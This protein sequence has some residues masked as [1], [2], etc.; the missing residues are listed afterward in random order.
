MAS[1]ILQDLPKEKYP[2]HIA[3]IM[4]G[5]GR[6]AKQRN[7]IR[8]F[9]H[10][11]GISTVRETV[12][13]C[14]QLGIGFLTLY[15]FSTENWSRP[16]RER[17]GLWALLK[18]YLQSELPE[19][20][21]KGVRLKIIGDFD[22]LPKDVRKV[23]RSS[24]DELSGGQGLVLTIALSYSSRDEIVG[25]IRKIARKARDT[26]FDI[27]SIDEALVAEHLQTSDMPDPDLLIRTS[28]E[29]RISN[30][31]MW[32]LAY[33]EIYVTP[34]LWPDFS[35]EELHKAILDYSCRERRFGKTGEQI[36]GS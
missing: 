15:A 23:I 9:G 19:L 28:G 4:D 3:I 34:T 24:T 27:E 16:P 2:H 6:W 26:N 22:R 25:A 10:R 35:P 33:S 36:K 13:E 30:F 5:N 11:Q 12:R 29:F 20:K 1:G 14:H 21:K 8:L 17:R 32:Q 18:Y 31:L 7:R